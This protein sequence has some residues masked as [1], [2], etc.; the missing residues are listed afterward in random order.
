VVIFFARRLSFFAL[1]FLAT[2]VLIFLLVRLIGGSPASVLLGEYSTPEDVYILETQL[3]LHQSLFSQY[4]EWVSSL[5]KGNFGTS[6]YNGIELSLLL[7]PALP[8]SV[9]LS[10]GALIVGLL[11]GV[12]FGIASALR[13]FQGKGSMADFVSQLGMAIPIFWSGAV[14]SIIFGVHLGWLPTGGWV[15]WSSD[16]ASALRHL[17]LPSVTLGIGI[18]SVLSR[19][20]RTAIVEVMRQDY[21]RTG[22]AFGMS[23]Q[24]AL[25]IVGLRNA[26][27]PVVTVF[28]NIVS[29]LV[30]GTVLT[31]TLFSMPGLSRMI[32]G[33]VVSRDIFVV[34]NLAMLLILFVLVVNLIVDVSYYFL[35]KRLRI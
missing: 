21:V 31:E 13:S 15:P 4:L 23:L 20:I 32:L 8:V 19:F 1:S 29:H 11:V 5:L 3:G 10:I 25:F 27:L 26:S 30:G 22:R 34:Q 7:S 6:F 17:V 12:P 14:L 18:G 24:R 28:G 16:P 33:A 9:S 2:S 35:D